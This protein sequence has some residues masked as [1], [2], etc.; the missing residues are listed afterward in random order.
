DVVERG[1]A[2]R[3]GVLGDEVSHGGDRRRV[4]QGDAAQRAEVEDVDAVGVVRDVELVPYDLDVVLGRGGH[5]V[6]G[7]PLGKED[8]RLEARGV[9][10]GEPVAAHLLDHG[11]EA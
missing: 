5:G 10:D 11:D 6:A 4:R 9:V 1:G 3:G 2:V 8:R 7:V